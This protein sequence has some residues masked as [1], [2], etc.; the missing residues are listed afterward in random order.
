MRG[1]KT[2]ICTFQADHTRAARPI[3]GAR[4]TRLTVLKRR[5]P[6]SVV[7]DVLFRLKSDRLLVQMRQESVKA[8][9]VRH[10]VN[11]SRVRLGQTHAAIEGVQLRG[12]PPRQTEHAEMRRA[13]MFVYANAQTDAKR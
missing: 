1:E 6:P 13:D 12:M 7:F 8:F 5:K 4:T 10:G 9:L 11:E 2:L 3:S